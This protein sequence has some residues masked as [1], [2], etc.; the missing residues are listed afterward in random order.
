MTTGVLHQEARH[1]DDHAL[2]FPTPLSLAIAV[3][4]SATTT[5]IV[6]S[7]NRYSAQ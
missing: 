1:H 2:S 4:G 7:L 5:Q 6:G 3:I